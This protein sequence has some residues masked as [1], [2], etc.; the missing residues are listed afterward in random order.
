MDINGNFS[1]SKIST[2]KTIS[3]ANSLGH[4]QLIGQAAI[5]N[6]SNSCA[7][8]RLVP[9]QIIIQGIVGNCRQNVVVYI[10]IQS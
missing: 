10:T 2:I 8:N 3:G 4:I 7:A 5:F 9:I 1:K 6:Q